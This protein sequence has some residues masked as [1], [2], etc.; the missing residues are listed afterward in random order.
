MFTTKGRYALRLMIDLAAN[1]DLGLVPLKDVAERQDVSKKYLEIIAKELVT[2]G[3]I[4]SASGK[5]GG[6]KLLRDPSEYSV[7]EIIELMEGSFAP[8]T[9][10]EENADKCDRSE[11]CKTLSM[12]N[13]FYELEKNFFYEKKLSDLL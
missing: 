4:A 11:K 8:V 7:G 9:C 12:W 13:E 1:K 6:Y 5:H 3:L 10:L 2:N